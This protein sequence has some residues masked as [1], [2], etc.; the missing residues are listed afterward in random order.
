MAQKKRLTTD[1]FIMRSSIK[2]CNKYLYDKSVFI[3]SKSKIKIICNDH[4]EFDQNPNKHMTGSGCPKCGIINHSGPK[5]PLTTDVFIEKSNIIH[6]NKYDYSLVNYQNAH[7][8]I[9]IICKEHGE[10][11]QEPTNHLMGKGC[12][13]CGKIKIAQSQRSNTDIFI[14][15]ANVIHND[16]YD[17]SLSDYS[18]ARSKLKIKCAKH[19]LVFE[20]T[21][22]NHLRGNGCWKCSTSVSNLESK[23]L[24]ICNIPDG[25]R[26]FSLHIEDKLIKCDGYDPLT[27]TV[28]EFYGDFWHGNPSLYLPEDTNHISNIKFGTLYQKL[29]DR[30]KL[31]IRNDYKII[32]IWENEFISKFKDKINLQCMRTRNKKIIPN[33]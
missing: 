24:D 33:D 7:T 20:Q 22:D 17:Y 3:N 30:E 27:K 15:K 11:I 32:S 2:H 10:F 6:N 4:G 12:R 1:D 26:Q 5:R 31:I 9:K 21:P 13:L 8:N 28:Y 25:Y 19:D 29:I 16:K 18:T 14:A 23:W